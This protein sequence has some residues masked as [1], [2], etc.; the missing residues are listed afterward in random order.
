MPDIP[1]T[2]LWDFSAAALLKPRLPPGTR[3]LAGK[4]DGFGAVRFSAR[5]IGIDS[6]G[7]IRWTDIIE[8]HTQPPLDAMT[9]AAKDTVI[10]TLTR[11][12][13]VGRGMSARVLDE[14]VEVVLGM[15]RRAERDSVVPYEFVYRA[16]L[17]RRTLTP[18]LVS[19]AVL[20]LPQVA[21][22]V[23]ATA[24]ANG[25]ARSTVARSTKENQRPS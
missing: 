24:A 20:A 22:S 17:R 10:T 11:M 8:I 14:M 19:A 23:L 18:G 5:A 3:W 13:P 12:L 1:A 15:L 6:T 4:L 25:V 7:P 21:A 9:G 2:E 16:W